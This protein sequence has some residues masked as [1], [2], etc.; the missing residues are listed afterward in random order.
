MIGGTAGGGTAAGGGRVGAAPAFSRRTSSSLD[1]RAIVAD[2][3][4]SARIRS[5][6]E[7]VTVGSDA[8]A[9]SAIGA[10][11][12]DEAASPDDAGSDAGAASARATIAAG[13]AL[14]LVTGLGVDRAGLGAGVAAV[15]L[16]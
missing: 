1:R 8:G 14:I 15:G 3:S 11:S 16:A 12:A 13:A 9:G 6:V 7:R 5:A 10:D 2:C 4:S